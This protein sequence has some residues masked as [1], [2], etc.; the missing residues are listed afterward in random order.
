MKR[1]L[2]IARALV[3]E[4]ELLIL[5]EPTAGVDLEL[6]HGMY[7]FLRELNKNGTTIILTTH[8]LEEAE[9]LCRNMAIIDRGT[10]VR[11]GPIRELLASMEDE[12]VSIELD[13]E[14]DP[15]TKSLANYT[16]DIH[17]TLIDVTVSSKHTLDDAIQLLQTEGYKIKNIRPKSG[18][19]EE[20][21]LKSTGK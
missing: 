9:S 6:R 5:D 1:R 18:R 10:I 17:D 4:P 11:S 20:F 2:M 3:H 12:V 14:Y 19:L 15:N 8:Y 13:R 7:E 16:V 21:F